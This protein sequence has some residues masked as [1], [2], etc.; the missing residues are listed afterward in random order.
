ML[1]FQSRAHL[2]RRVRSFSLAAPPP[3]F[4]CSHLTGY[5]DGKWV[6]PSHTTFDVKNP[7]TG[8]VIAKVADMSAGSVQHA[9]A[10]AVKAQSA[11][12]AEPAQSRA[13]LL[14]EL[15]RLMMKNADALATLLSLECGKP[16]E[17]AKGEIAYSASFLSWFSEE[18][19]RCDGQVIPAPR[20]DRRMLA[21][22][23][24]VGASKPSLN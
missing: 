21:L 6:Q 17:E 1:R 13:A 24:P 7:A 2:L 18:A 23:V 22:R 8:E 11:W 12:G 20:S 15:H 10:A 4:A 9:V 5:I 16:W 14:M 19:K 3:A